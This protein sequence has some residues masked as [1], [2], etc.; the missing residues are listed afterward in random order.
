MKKILALAL[1]LAMVVSLCACGG[2]NT[3]KDGSAA[4][5][6]GNTAVKAGFI[7]L[8]DENSTYDLNFIN[9]AKEACESMGIEYVFKTNIPEGQ[10][11][12]DAACELAVQR[13]TL[14]VLTTSTMRS[15]L[16]TKAVTSQVSLQV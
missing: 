8:H 13:L 16:S 3:S 1:T 5:E 10:E 15:L 7:F 11:A 14:R 9:A 4:A 12:F 6:G 2:G